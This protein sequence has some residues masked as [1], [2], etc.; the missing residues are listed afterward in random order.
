MKLLLALL[1]L[2]WS[3]AP[4]RVQLPRAPLGAPSFA[5]PLA[6]SAA[7]SAALQLPGTMPRLNAVPS[8]AAPSLAPSLPA[9]PLSPLA[10]LAP[11]P[12]NEPMSQ[13]PAARDIHPLAQPI[14]AALPSQ[15]ANDVSLEQRSAD[16]AKSF[17]NAAPK[18][19][20]VVPPADGVPAYLSVPNPEDRPWVAKVLEA[21]QGSPTGRKVL[22]RI[23]KLTKEQ[24]RPLTLVVLDLRSN[25]GEYVYDWEVV[26]LASS[27]RK[28]DPLFA[29]PTIVHELLHVLQ[30]ADGLPVDAVEMELEAHLITLR[31][32]RELGVPLMPGSFEEGAHKALKKSAAKFVK[33]VVDAYDNNRPLGQGGLKAYVKWVEESRAA[34]SKR[35]AK[36]EK[37]LARERGIIDAMKDSGQTAESISKYE[38]EIVGAIELKLLVE[39]NGL[40][41]N[42]RDLRILSTPEGAA[43]YRAFAARVRRMIREGRSTFLKP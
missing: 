30:K 38:R 16:A 31:V 36:L 6:P 22:S 4:M 32:I 35:V 9:A 12:A 34:A 29:A 18:P 7:V 27:F 41:W 8:F 23:E 3:A 21:A 33:Y 2:S 39:R 1:S 19:E 24:G 17:D 11:A 25:N 14:A 20:A 40:A 42:E 13:A 10:P 28:L 26:R 43:R 37:R 5:V 15:P